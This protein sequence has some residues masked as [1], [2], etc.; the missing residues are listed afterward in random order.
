MLIN[1]WVNDEFVN[2][3]Y[4]HYYYRYYLQAINT[5]TLFNLDCGRTEYESRK[6]IGKN[7]NA[8]FNTIKQNLNPSE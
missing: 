2:T 3:Y 7:P 1:L 6:I 4:N 8:M 5:N